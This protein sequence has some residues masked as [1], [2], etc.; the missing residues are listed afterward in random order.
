MQLEE[1]VV[2]VLARRHMTV[3]AAE[4]CTGGLIAGTLVNAAG[5]SEVLNEGYVTYSNEAKERL[6]GVRHDTLAVYGAVSAQTAEEMACGAAKAAGAD[7]ALSATGIAG[8][9]GGSKE[10]PVGL[11]YI[12]CFVNGETAVKECHF[13]GDRMEN[14]KRT[15]Q[16]A[17]EMLLEM[18]EKVPG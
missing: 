11:V 15:V 12:G 10:K 9:G 2:E 4:S 14:R 16:A 6:V 5:A 7:A 17:L 1:R 18:L 8:P 13:K 3:T